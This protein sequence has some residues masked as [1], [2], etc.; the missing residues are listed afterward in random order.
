MKKIL[1]VAAAYAVVSM[2][3]PAQ[4]SD[5]HSVQTDQFVADFA[6]AEGKKYG[7]L[8]LGG[9][10]GGKPKDL[11][12]KIADM[13]YPVLSL[14][15]FKEEGLPQELNEIPLEYFDAPKDWLQA[16]ADTKDDGVIVVGW[17]KG[18]ELSLLLASRDPS[19]KGV[20]AIAPS[21]VV[22]A[23]ILKDWTKIPS[24]SWTVGGEPMAHVPFA[25]GVQI[26]S[27]VDLYEASLKQ[28]TF[29]EKAVIPAENI[30]GSVLLMSGGMDEIWPA[31]MMADDVCKRMEA[32]GGSCSHAHY[33][34]AGHL[35]NPDYPIGGTD[36]GNKK[37]GVDSTAKMK[38]FLKK[39]N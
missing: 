14:A 16:R 9:S 26:N 36:E 30:R 24:S 3:V 37:A 18:A 29:A 15:Y 6:P 33:P 20:M 17:S 39:L 8:V 28:E 4:A 27:L 2:A 25:Q 23:G 19:Y 5:F 12:T 10:E 34:D 35:L 38:A 7:V 22:W 13:G 31:G 1:V 32:A 21:S 11:A